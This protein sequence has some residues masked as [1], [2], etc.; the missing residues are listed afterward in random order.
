MGYDAVGNMVSQD[1][2]SKD[3]KKQIHFDSENRISFVEDN[4]LQS[5]NNIY[6]NGVRIA[7]LNEEGVAAYFLTDQVDSVGQ[8]LDDN[9]H[10]VS[11]MQYEPYGETFVQR[12]NQNFSPKYNSQELDKETSLYFYN[13]RYYDPKIARFASADT[14]IPGNGLETQGWNRFSY[15]AG[16]PIRYK[17]PTGHELNS[18]FPELQKSVNEFNAYMLELSGNGP[19]S[20]K[21]MINHLNEARSTRG[22][23]GDLA[24]ISPVSDETIA[25]V[26]ND[27][28]WTIPIHAPGIRAYGEGQ[29]I[30]KYTTA[31]MRDHILDIG[32]EMAK[33]GEIIFVGDGSLPKGGPTNWHGTHRNGLTFDMKMSGRPFEM[34][35]DIREGVGTGARKGKTGEIYDRTRTEGLFRTILDK[36]LSSK[37]FS[38]QLI[39]FNDRNLNAKLNK[40][41]AGKFG[42]A[43]FQEFRG[44]DDH[45]H[46]QFKKK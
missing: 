38:I 34:V 17:D 19:V 1:D 8:I 15:V 43:I 46:I 27:I 16:N 45:F 32:R 10:T 30:H 41:Y 21:T 12:G 37:E 7:A 13:A 42:G 18:P 26:N 4:T 28:I 33:R 40:E 25:S 11:R 36:T 6:L 24:L 20:K 5:I 3:L 23:S 9:A 29:R 31:Y 39:Y 22:Y 14:I 44:H 35:Y 2:N